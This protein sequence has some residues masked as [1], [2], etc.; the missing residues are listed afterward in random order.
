MSAKEIYEKETGRKP[1]NNQIAYH[2]WHIEYVNWLEQRIIKKS[3]P[4]VRLSTSP[5]VYL[6]NIDYQPTVVIAQNIA[7]A[8]DKAE[9]ICKM[10]YEMVY[11]KSLPL[12][13]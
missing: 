4:I 9:K 5:T 2:E 13:Y 6:M 7:E 12:L 1:P 3:T 11:H 10:D 8:M